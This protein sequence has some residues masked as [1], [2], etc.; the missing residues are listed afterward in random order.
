[1]TTRLETLTKNIK[2]ILGKS[3]AKQT[4]HLDEL[5][6]ECEHTCLS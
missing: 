4:V 5:T 2:T 6:I 3:I 1:M